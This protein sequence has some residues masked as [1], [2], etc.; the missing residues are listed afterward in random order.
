MLDCEVDLCSNFSLE[1]K[2]NN[3]SQQSLCSPYGQGPGPH[4]GDPRCPWK[5][6]NRKIQGLTLQKTQDSLGATLEHPSSGQ[7]RVPKCRRVFSSALRQGSC[8]SAALLSQTHPGGICA[9][10]RRK[11]THQRLLRRKPSPVV[12]GPT[13]RVSPHQTR[14][15]ASCA[16]LSGIF[17]ESSSGLV[18]SHPP[19]WLATAFR[20][21]ILSTA[22]DSMFIPK[23]C[24]HPTETYI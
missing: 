14:R 7:V 6:P 18:W 15:R 12:W 20:W 13:V 2:Q 17:Q 24:P 10:R 8:S 22:A 5:T 1:I 9:G 11:S 23:D 3:Q 4:Q 21:G 16:H 19:C